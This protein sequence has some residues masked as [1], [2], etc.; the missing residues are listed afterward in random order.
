MFVMSYFINISPGL[1]IFARSP[2]ASEA[3]KGFGILNL[4]G[5]STLIRKTR[6]F[7]HEPG[8]DNNIMRL[9]RDKYTAHTESLEKLGHKKPMGVGL[10]IFDEVKVISKVIWNSKSHEFIGTA[11]TPKEESSLCDLYENDGSENQLQGAS[12][13]VQYLWRD[14][15]SKYDIIG[16]YF[17][18]PSNA[19]SETITPFVNSCIHAFQIF[20]FKIAAIV[21]DGASSNLSSLKSSLGLKATALPPTVPYYDI[22]VSFKNPHHCYKDFDIPYVICPSHQVRKS[23]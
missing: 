23:L 2:S 1:A 4:P 19:T 22:P 18:L 12:Y 14:L 6:C 21:C 8:T 10:L 15:T 5:R 7:N 20:N 11:M 17:T 9:E 13:V 16:P 3:L